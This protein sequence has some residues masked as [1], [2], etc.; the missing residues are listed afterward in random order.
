MRKIRIAERPDPV[1]P[2]RPPPSQPDPIRDW[3]ATLPILALPLMLLWAVTQMSAAGPELSLTTSSVR[4]GTTIDLH[5][6][7]FERAEAGVVTWD[8]APL[9]GSTYRANGRGSFV[10]SVVVPPDAAP[11]SHEIAAVHE[12]KPKRQ[13]ADLAQGTI[14]SVIAISVTAPDASPATVT[15][16]TVP[17]P[18]AVIS[19]AP[20]A[21]TPTLSPIA[22]TAT[23][24]PTLEAPAPTA[25]PSA[26]TQP[27]PT[28]TPGAGGAT[29][30][31]SLQS[32]VDAAA[33]GAT[34]TAP[35]CTYRETITITKPITLVTAGGKI[36]GQGSRKYAFVVKTNDVTI[37]G[38]EV[39][40][41]VN[42]AQEGA[43][44]VRNSAR[45]TLRNVYIHH[46]G[47]ACISIG[48]GG[49][50]RILD[51]ELAYCE[52]Q[53]YHLSSVTD[54]LVAGNKIH[55]NNPN[56]AYGPGW[57]A[58]G[59]KAARVNGLTFE[60]NEVYA[61]IGPGLWCDV[62]CRNVVYRNNRLHHN[63]RMGI[64]FEISN[65]ALIEGN[66][67]WE[68]GW[69]FTSW[70]YGAGIVAASSRNVE[71]RNNVVAWNADG[72][73]II[74]QNR[75]LDGVTQT[76]TGVYVHGNTIFLAP[77]PSDSSM[78]HLL[79]WQQ[80]WAGTLYDAASNNRGANNSYWHSYSEPSLRFEWT[81]TMGRLSDFNATPGGSSGRYLSRAEMEAAMASAG[82]PASPEA[83]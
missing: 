5:G 83:H 49:G 68:N 37:D 65:G 14:R 19:P 20:T 43:I 42:P 2:R 76:V 66:V 77:Q 75:T 27:A 15:P 46:T 7:G 67:A 9:S 21:G 32:V 29:C 70:G 73:S 8:G 55:H 45:F 22:A 18:L 59:G 50:H 72:I 38:F 36:D 56:G 53:G 64:L 25:Q 40:G 30:P 1:T 6:R 62:D 11:G 4:P 47:G 78:S 26:A 13:G 58:G 74:S 41:T 44:Q 17:S 81:K 79:A 16:S 54:T 24:A 71:I 31:A 34:V 23:P 39:T 52:Q 12:S 63:S 48:T 33:A 10:V 51:S 69:Q 28:P 80:D 82:A 3:L 35:A 60:A 57:E 61:N